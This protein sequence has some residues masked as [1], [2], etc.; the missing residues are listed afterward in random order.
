MMLSESTGAKQMR[1]PKFKCIRSPPLGCRSSCHVRDT[2]AHGAK[3]NFRYS[4]QQRARNERVEKCQRDIHATSIAD[5]I[6]FNSSTST[7][8]SV[9]SSSSN[10]RSSDRRKPRLTDVADSLPVRIDGKWYNLKSW[11]S[12]HP[13]GK[14]WIHMYHS[15]D[16]TDVFYAFHSDMA[17]RIM[18]R[19]PEM[20]E[21]ET[22]AL[23]DASPLQEDFRQLREELVEDGWFERNWVQET[24]QLASYAFLLGSAIAMTTFCTGWMRFLAFLPL[25]CSH[26]YVGWLAHDYIHGRGRFCAALRDIG[27]WGSGFSASMWSDKHNT[28][29]A[30]TNLVGTDEDLSGG[31]LLWLWSPDPSR[32][33]GWR[34]FQ[35]IYVGALFS[36]LHVVWRIDSLRVAWKRRIWRELI[37]IA[38]HYVA[39]FT[40]FPA[41]TVVLS[42]LFGSL[43]MAN[44]TSTTHQSE[45]LL[46]EYEH[47]WIKMQFKTTRNAKCLTPFSEWMWG[48]M[49]YQLE[50]HLFPT[51]PRYYYPALVPKIMELA[52]RHNI[53]YRQS[54]EFEI[55]RQNYCTYFRVAK[56][57]PSVGAPSSISGVSV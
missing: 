42:I 23:P 43:L 39:W 17:A 45:D 29:H 3:L 27:A 48:G 20:D 11:A 2:I 9:D 50:H 21:P 18:T 51:M 12:R 8:T 36:L 6:S 44:I 47:D 10:I 56:L 53:E 19:M 54:T 14:H 57:P 34:P 26:C 5:I 38:I 28:H 32:D 37:P 16:A 55:I 1:Q 35:H 30:M 52:E 15:L 22:A 31:P 4:R 40:L 33:R 41:S 46:Y 25:G 24:F 49:Q 13:A 7:S